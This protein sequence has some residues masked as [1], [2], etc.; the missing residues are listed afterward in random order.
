MR[1][2]VALHADA[3]GLEVAQRHLCETIAGEQ[4]TTLEE[5]REIM[6]HGAF[7]GELL[8]RRLGARWVDLEPGHPERWAMLVPAPAQGPAALSRVWPIGRV[9]RFV[10]KR[11]R[12][13]DLVAYYLGLE[14]MTR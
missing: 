13:R 2:G 11:H 7:L 12:E 10:A 4:A 14:A 5:H 3:D 1:H 9:L 6:R 8:A